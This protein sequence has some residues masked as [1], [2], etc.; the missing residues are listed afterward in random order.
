MNWAICHSTICRRFKKSWLNIFLDNLILIHSSST[1][2]KA[3]TLST[4]VRTQKAQIFEFI[5]SASCLLS[6]RASAG[7]GDP[8]E[9]IVYFLPSAICHSRP[10]R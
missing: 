7:V 1:S 4:H 3:P 8:A 6:G 9:G 2:D 5:S 10:F